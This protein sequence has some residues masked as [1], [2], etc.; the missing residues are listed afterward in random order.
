MSIYEST[1]NFLNTVQTVKTETYKTYHELGLES[2]GDRR[3]MPQTC[4]FL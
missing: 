4:M 1:Q 2:L 3:W